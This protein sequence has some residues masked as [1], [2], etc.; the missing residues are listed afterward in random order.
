MDL[1][2]SFTSGPHTSWDRGNLSS[3]DL[4]RREKNKK[5][6]FNGLKNEVF[7]SYWLSIRIDGF[8]PLFDVDKKGLS[9]PSLR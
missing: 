9:L 3:L 4:E 6:T 8:G 7:D 2:I 1:S 5:W